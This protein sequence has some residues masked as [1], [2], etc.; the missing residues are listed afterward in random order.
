M[1][2]IEINLDRTHLLQI[3]S[4]NINEAAFITDYVDGITD[5]YLKNN[6]L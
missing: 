5:E 4:A 3:I 6:L 1:R 2:C